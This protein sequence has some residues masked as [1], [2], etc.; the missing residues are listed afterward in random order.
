MANNWALS[1]G[2]TDRR[3][4]GLGWRDQLV[5]LRRVFPL[6]WPK[7]EAELK[8]RVTAALALIFLGKLVNVALPMFYGWIVDAL[9]TGPRAALVVPVAL[10]LGYGLVRVASSATTEIRDLVFA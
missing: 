9:S 8:L 10:I 4:A 2:R 6:L 7:G 5:V 3:E 1:R